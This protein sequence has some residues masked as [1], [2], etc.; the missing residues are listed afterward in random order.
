M[1]DCDLTLVVLHQSVASQLRPE[2]AADAAG[3]RCDHRLARGRQPA[4]AP[5]PHHSCR[6]HQVLHLVRPVTLELDAFGAAARRT[7]D[8]TATRGV[9]LPRPRCL[10]G[11][12]MRF[13]SVPFSMPLGLIEGRPFKPFTRAISSR[14]A[15]TIR[16]SS[17]SRQ[18]TPSPELPACHVAD[19]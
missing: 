19:R 2:M 3:Q 6:Q 17:Q 8:S 1:L 9:A 14:C 18:A 11:L 13:G 12:P 10:P 7:S 4:F 16:F 15:A 5:I